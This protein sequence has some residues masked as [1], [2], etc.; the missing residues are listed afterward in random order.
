[1]MHQ[2]ALDQAASPSHD[3]DG[4]RAKRIVLW[5]DEMNDDFLNALGAEGIEVV[6]LIQ[7]SHPRVPSFSLHDLFYG[8][9][10]LASFAPVT[11][12]PNWI[13][14]ASYRLYARCVQRVGFYPASDFMETASGGVTPS[15][16][17]EDWA[18]L[19]LSHAL[20]LLDGVAADEVWFCF[21]P[22]LGIDNMVAL[23]AQRTGRKCLVFTQ[24][25]SV[26]KFSWKQL[27]AD[28]GFAPPCLI[29]KPWQIGATQ[30]NLF[31]MRADDTAPWNRN[32]RERLGFLTRRL[33]QGNWSAMSSRMYL[34]AR[35]RSWWFLMFCIELLDVRTRPWAFF[36]RHF[37][38]RFD[39]QRALRETCLLSD[40]LGNFVY[41]PLH[42]EPEEN[43]H[44]LGGDFT[45]QLDAIVAVHDHLPP[46]WTL[47]LKENPRQTFLHRGQPFAMR[48][49]AL[50]Q[51]RFVHSQVSSEL[52]ISRSQLVATIT[53]TAGY[54]SM[55]LGRACLHFGE[56]WYAGLPGAVQFEP[57][58]DIAA[59]STVRI[60]RDELDQGINRL[61]SSLADGLAHPRYAG[62]FKHTHDIPAVY[63]EAAVSM[64]AI[65]ASIPT[66]WSTR[67]RP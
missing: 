19:H 66:S 16:D 18:R 15:T 17:I 46:G 40:D 60:S 52:L 34:A 41:Y 65:S 31:Y 10:E 43:V 35:K 28:P 11:A 39:R 2:L 6:A 27:G 1:M 29:W 49:A 42:L 21:T 5:I 26:L 33:R 30:P 64:S 8:C 48:L 13:D 53:G 4:P 50:R 61:L 58:I 67:E 55:M 36:R 57:G 45:N 24:I 62:I 54:E 47:V 32:L 38:K 14:D 7:A 12:P 44:V 3:R 22:H 56:A 9:G 51:V 25:R 20:Q 23:A 37:R 63:R 59:L